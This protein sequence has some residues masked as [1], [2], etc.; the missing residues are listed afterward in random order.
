MVMN[1]FKPITR[2]NAIDPWWKCWPIVSRLDMSECIILGRRYAFDHNKIV[3]LINTIAKN[4]NSTTW[5]I[6]YRVI[7]K[8]RY[9]VIKTGMKPGYCDVDE[10]MLQACMSLLCDYIEKEEGGEDEVA[11][12]IKYLEEQKALDPT[13]PS[14]SID[15][16]KEALE[17]YHW[18]KRER[19]DWIDYNDAVRGIIYCKPMEFKETDDP[20]LKKLVIHTNDKAPMTADECWKLEENLNK[21]DEEMLIRLM[22]IRLCLWT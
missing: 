12:S 3:A 4:F 13:Y 9:H 19:Q 22:K 8:H 17:I 1:I 10:R 14:S 15:S 6:K 21:K 20:N 18:W 7:P 2:E 16:L 11:K 5:W